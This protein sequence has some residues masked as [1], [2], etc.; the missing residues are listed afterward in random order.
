MALVD[1]Q[2]ARNKKPR[3]WCIWYVELLASIEPQLHT[4]GDGTH[5]S[6]TAKWLPCHQWSF[7]SFSVPPTGRGTN[8]AAM[9][10]VWWDIQT[11]TD[12]RN[13]TLLFVRCTGYVCIWLCRPRP[14]VTETTSRVRLHRSCSWMDLPWRLGT[15]VLSTGNN[16]VTWC[17][18]CCWSWLSTLTTKWRWCND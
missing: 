5:C 11:A 18:Q 9:L 6:D 1:S 16:W 14:S 10:R 2:A 17:D 4:E 3:T 12:Q 7:A 13:V 8:R 15:T